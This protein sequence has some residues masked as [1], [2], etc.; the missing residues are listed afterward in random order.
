MDQTRLKLKFVRSTVMSVV[1]LAVPLGS[2][3]STTDSQAGSG[4]RSVQSSG[5]GEFDQF[6]Q[7][8]ETSLSEMDGVTKGFLKLENV[9]H[10]SLDHAVVYG[11]YF[12][13]QKRFCFSVVFAQEPVTP[14][15][16]TSVGPGDIAELRGFNWGLAPASQPTS[17]KFF[18]VQQLVGKEQSPRTWAAPLRAP[19][20]VGASIP[21]SLSS[22]QLD[23]AFLP[24]SERLENIVLALVEIGPQGSLQRIETL[25]SISPG[26]DTWFRGLAQQLTFF[27]PSDN[28]VPV[29]GQVLVLIQ[30]AGKDVSLGASEPIS[31]LPWV[32]AYANGIVGADV[33]PVTRI[34]FAPPS[35]KNKRA[36][37]KEWTEL[38]PAP[39]GFLKVFFLGSDWGRPAYEWVAD[40]SAP[41][42]LRREIAS[43][44]QS[45]RLV[46]R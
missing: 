39:P 31:A 37:D 18:L 5:V 19:I 3:T 42:H 27:P 33:P 45:V 2:A 22:L 8:R 29:A 11:E 9:S 26:T 23:A 24:P 6:W 7:V 35:G 28:K 4:G 36:N 21:E 12:D 30:A 44:T 40:P 38:P 15:A 16:S 14:G 32:R 20:T 17:V 34:V 25:N 13:A 43:S 46:P 10:A 41:N 1:M